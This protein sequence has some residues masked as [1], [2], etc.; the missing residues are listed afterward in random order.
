MSTLANSSIPDTIAKKQQQTFN[1][2][3]INF[4]L[5][6]GLVKHP[7]S[8]LDPLLTQ[9]LEGLNTFHSVF[10]KSDFDVPPSPS[11]SLDFVRNE[12]I[13]TACNLG[14]KAFKERNFDHAITFY[15]QAIEIARDR[16]GWES[17]TVVQ[18]QL[19]ELYRNRAQAYVWIEGWPEALADI[20]ASIDF[21]KENNIKAHVWKAGILQRM[22]RLEEASDALLYA[23]EFGAGY[24]TNGD[25][26]RV[27]DKVMQ[28]IHERNIKDAT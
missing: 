10:L 17:T 28:L 21:K 20:E 23:S 5:T 22:G 25:F 2:L 8:Y 1:L 16:P 4:D 27:W 7:D 26:M 15:T 19:Q 13:K 14:T 9:Y 18:E 24:S 11:I 6:T 12:Q 3:P